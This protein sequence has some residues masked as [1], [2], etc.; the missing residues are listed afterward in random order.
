MPRPSLKG[1][2]TEE[3]L[4]AFE[5]C[6]VRDGVTG[7]TLERVA[8]EVGLQRSLVRHYVGNRDELVAALISRFL[9]Q[10]KEQT[11]QLFEALPEEERAEALVARLFESLYSDDQLTMVALALMSA[12]PFDSQLNEPVG[13]WFQDFFQ[14]FSV[15]LQK[16][17]PSANPDDILDVAVGIIGVYVNAD[18]MAMIDD[19]GRLVK[20]SERTAYR[21]LATLN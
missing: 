13:Q 18:T 3:I 4:A 8:D 9:E 7:A 15:E 1:E 5:R 6:V 16:A 20:A 10:S 21:L 17:Y 14:A 2:R 11:Q 19:D 12:L